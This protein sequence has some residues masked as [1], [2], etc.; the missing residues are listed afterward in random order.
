MAT[1]A[2]K[3]LGLTHTSLVKLIKGL[4]DRQYMLNVKTLGDDWIKKA[5]KNDLIHYELAA[6]EELFEY[7]N[8]VGY[9]W[10][11][12]TPEVLDLKNIKMELIDTLHF[13]LSHIMAVAYSEHNELGSDPN[14]LLPIGDSAIVEGTQNLTKFL[15]RE[16][17]V[18]DRYLFIPEAKGSL[19]K[20]VRELIEILVFK[21]TAFD[22]ESLIFRWLQLWAYHGFT[23]RDIEITYVAKNLLNAFR[24]KYGYKEGI[25]MKMW[26]DGREDNDF[27][28]EWLEAQPSLPTDDEITQWLT[29][30]YFNH[31]KAVV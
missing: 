21:D 25:Y 15:V 24:Q 27:L 7:L 4:L 1:K 6:V 23:G 8:Y 29:T 19:L 11:K 30:Q 20:R 13:I 12:K 2:S 16:S 5:A 22:V 9:K 14:Y 17:C 3:K 10:W 28:I 18:T 31:R 26:A